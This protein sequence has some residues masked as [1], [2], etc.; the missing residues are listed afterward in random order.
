MDY[1]PENSAQLSALRQI[2]VHDRQNL[3][4]RRTPATPAFHAGKL[5][6]RI[7]DPATIENPKL[8]IGVRIGHTSAKLHVLPLYPQFRVTS[9]IQNIAGLEWLGL[10]DPPPIDKGAV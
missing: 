8:G 2:C 6:A 5:G 1:L 9:Q 10:R 7:V 3:F 4:H